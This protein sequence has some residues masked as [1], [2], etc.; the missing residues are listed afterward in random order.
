MNK[1][2]EK[3]ISKEIRRI[4]ETGYAMLTECNGEAFYDLFIDD[5]TVIMD[6]NLVP[7]WEEHRQAGLTFLGSLKKASYTMGKLQIEILNFETALA[8]GDFG[9]EIVDSQDTFIKGKGIQ[10]W[11]LVKQSNDWKVAH[12]HVSG[13]YRG[14]KLSTSL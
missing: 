3:M 2:E 8:L 1:T 13:Q 4:A 12:S 6:G 7:S 10:T 9:Y 5:A 14:A 11:V